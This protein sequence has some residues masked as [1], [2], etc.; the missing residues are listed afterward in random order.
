MLIIRS[1]LFIIGIAFRC[2]LHYIFI[3]SFLF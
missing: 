2:D 1:N 3:G